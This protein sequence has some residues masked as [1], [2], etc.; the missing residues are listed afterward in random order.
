MREALSAAELI[1]WPEDRE[2]CPSCK[3][4]VS[5]AEFKEHYPECKE[6]QRRVNA[7]EWYV[8]GKFQPA[9][10]AHAMSGNTTFSTAS[11]EIV[12]TP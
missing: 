5:R 7:L 3:K 6:K 12:T 1:I 9:M 4:V 10:R 8:N 2:D 11:V